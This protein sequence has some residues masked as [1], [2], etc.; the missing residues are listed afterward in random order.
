MQ[1]SCQ[2][3]CFSE[4]KKRIKHRKYYRDVVEYIR[5]YPAVPSTCGQCGYA[6]IT[7][8]PRCYCCG[9]QY[10]TTPRGNSRGGTIELMIEC[11]RERKRK[12]GSL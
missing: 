2:G 6:K 4:K 11:E 5:N 3:R 1:A 12:N 7:A 8:K 9:T 10:S